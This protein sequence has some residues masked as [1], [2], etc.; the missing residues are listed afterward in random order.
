M[1]IGIDYNAAL[2]QRAGIGRYTREL[3][4]ALAALDRENEYLLV[5]SGPAVRPGQDFLPDAANFRPFYL[6][7]GERWTTLLWQRLRLPLAIDWL[8]G[9][10]DLFHSPDYVLPPLRRGVNKLLTIHDLSFLRYPEGAEPTL[11]WYLEGA[12]PRS[13]AR[14]DL[15]LA[16]S[17][18]TRR[19]LID[20]FHVDPQRVEVI[21]PGVDERFR[22]L[23]DRAR[24]QEVRRRYA[25]DGPFILSVGTLEPRKNYPR[26]IEA[27]HRLRHDTHIPHRLVIVGGLGWRYAGVFR[28]VEQLGL[29]DEVRFLGHVPEEDLIALYNLCEAFAFVSLYEGFGLP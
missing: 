15:L 10:V 9:S 19:D 5:I 4:K 11:R 1:R 21:Y 8:T 20:L 24:L 27:F 7:L 17:E 22:P 26:L 29:Q 25:L 14:A 18:S 3:F 16:D 23:P 6:L 12:V 13:V 2:H 28:S